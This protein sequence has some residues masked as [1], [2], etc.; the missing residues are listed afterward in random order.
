[1]SLAGWVVICVFG[2]VFMWAFLS[3]LEFPEIRYQKQRDKLQI[4]QQKLEQEKKSTQKELNDLDNSFNKYLLK[5]SEYQ[6]R[7]K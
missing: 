1:M 7:K 4:K 3:V 2:V 5:E 6:A